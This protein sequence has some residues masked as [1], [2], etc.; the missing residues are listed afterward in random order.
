[1]PE[2][3]LV[4]PPGGAM[5][6]S[7]S[8]D[9]KLLEMAQAKRPA[10]TVFR[11]AEVL[12]VFT[13]EWLKGDVA[14]SDGVIV[15]VGRYE[16]EEEIDCRGKAL[17]P[18][19]IDAHLHV[20]SSMLTP[21]ALA[22][23]VLPSGTTALIADPHE[24]ANVCG[25]PGLRY[26]LDAARALPLSLF[27]MLPSCVPATKWEQGGAVLDAASLATLRDDPQVLGL[28]EV[29]DYPAVCAGDPGLLAKLEAFSGRMI[30]GHAPLLSGGGLQAYRLAGIETDHECSDGMETLEKL[31]AGFAVLVREGSA[32]H[33]LE[34]ILTAV[35]T[36]GIGTGRLAFCTDDK[37]IEDIRREGHI[38]HN[39]RRAIALGI[40]AADAYR[41]ASWNAARIYGL[42]GCGAIGPGYRAD[43]V[44]LNDK[45]EAAVHAVYTGGIRRWREGEPI[46]APAGIPIPAELRGTV[47]VRPS[48]QLWNIQSLAL[49]VPPDGVMPVIELI[50]RQINTRRRDLP[51]PQRDGF[52]AAGG[53]FLKAAV[54]ERHHATGRI[55]LGVVKGLGL[56]GTAAST[57]AHDS[58]NLI[59]LGD[60]DEDMLLAVQELERCGGGYTL[61]RDG[62]A[63]ATLPLPVAGLMTDRPADE[64]NGL[65]RRMSALSRELGVPEWFDPF[66]TMSFLSL[67]VIP[68]LRLT[69]RGVFDVGEQRYL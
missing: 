22:A 20:E 39:I 67:P 12:N 69:D 24:I 7:T 60:R 35:Q 19:F 63:L 64:V 58:H 27:I 68:E 46:P 17:V 18:G 59:V 34:T 11:G 13:G 36:A 3:F 66:Q 9:R 57:V 33:N 38:R 16:G 62:R 48:G 54:L 43:L 10:Q 2:V 47:H 15:G 65:L 31:R 29:M 61:V 1:M 44:L 53:D 50:P 25:L 56:R 5:G 26:M 55:G 32:A 49:P 51:V 23:E 40:P 52:F 42:R 4:V 41:M 21:A 45:Q 30:D 37:H 6:V 28:G 14:V 8:M